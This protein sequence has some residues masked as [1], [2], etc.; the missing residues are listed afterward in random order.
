VAHMI[1]VMDEVSFMKTTW[2]PEMHAQLK[3]H[4][5]KRY[6]CMSRAHQRLQ[7]TCIYDDVCR[8]APASCF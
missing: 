7:T 2:L 3:E 5:N 1:S 4:I 6:A 8:D